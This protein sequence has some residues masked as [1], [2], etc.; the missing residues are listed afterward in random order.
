MTRRR[1]LAAL[2]AVAVAGSLAAGCGPSL[3]EVA[4]KRDECVA[5]GGVFYHSRN[6]LGHR[7]F[8]DLGTGR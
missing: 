4:K 1:M 7:Y 3:E 2:A 8:C 5:L 6:E